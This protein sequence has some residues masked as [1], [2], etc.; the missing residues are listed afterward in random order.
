ME[1]TVNQPLQ[2]CAQGM[3]PS[4]GNIAFSLRLISFDDGL[5]LIETAPEGQ[6][7]LV[8]QFRGL[9]PMRN[10]P[11]KVLED[12]DKIEDSWSAPTLAERGLQGRHVGAYGVWVGWFVPQLYECA[13]EDVRSKSI[14]DTI[15]VPHRAPAIRKAFKVVYPLEG[16]GHQ[17]RPYA[18]CEPDDNGICSA[19]AV[20]GG[21]EKV[22]FL[23][24]WRSDTETTISGRRAAGTSLITSATA[25]SVAMTEKGYW[26]HSNGK[27]ASM[28]LSNNP[29]N[30]ETYE[31][32]ND[33]IFGPGTLMP[34][35]ETPQ[36]SASLGHAP[37]GVCDKRS[38]DITAP[39][40][41]ARDYGRSLSS[42]E[43]I[44]NWLDKVQSEA[45]QFRPGGVALPSTTSTGTTQSDTLKRRSH[46][47]IERLGQKHHK[48]DHA[49]A[50]PS[51]AVRP[52]VEQYCPIKSEPLD[53]SSPSHVRNDL[54]GQKRSTRKNDGQSQQFAEQSR[55]IDAYIQNFASGD[56]LVRIARND[57]I[58]IRQAMLAYFVTQIEE[59]RW[60]CLSGVVCEIAYADDEKYRVV[61]AESV[62]WIITKQVNHDPPNPKAVL[63]E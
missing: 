36:P 17:F 20:P 57:D 49:M 34:P 58:N 9:I 43:S 18:L 56:T 13:V 54:A 60:S 6:V 53:E 25:K 44:S 42:H 19:H 45:P 1:G 30:F 63:L 8:K 33:S 37:P 31:N 4:N 5:P 50:A 21:A 35:T 29:V 11:E 7:L 27:S 22:M 32:A 3:A 39:E 40:N 41:Q 59:S 51:H 46:D 24:D 62:M 10:T 2:S 14:N 52:S 16:P 38:G 47:E 61:A 26:L 48:R 15:S 12:W 28:K 55:G 23:R